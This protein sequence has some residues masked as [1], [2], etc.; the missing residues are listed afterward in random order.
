VTGALVSS[1]FVDP[2]KV[3]FIP[4]WDEAATY[5]AKIAQPGDFFITLGCGDVYRIIPSVLSALEAVRDTDVT[6]NS[7]P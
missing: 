2:S 4:S 5:A 7:S 6:R 3:A 1:A